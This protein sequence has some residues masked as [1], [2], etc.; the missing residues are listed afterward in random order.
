MA[1]LTPDKRVAA[2]GRGKEK[3]LKSPA[4]SVNSQKNRPVFLHGIH[5]QLL[6]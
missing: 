1:A 6:I 5:L 2:T 4:E 3:A